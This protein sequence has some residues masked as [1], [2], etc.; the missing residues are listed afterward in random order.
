LHRSLL[1]GTPLVVSGLQHTFQGE[2][3]P[4]YFIE[5][6]GHHDVTVMD[7]E[8]EQEHKLTVAEFFRTFG[9][10]RNGQQ[11]LKLKVRV[12]LTRS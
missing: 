11:V 6:Y 5:A 7:C 3:G 9:S 4:E 10:E 1:T 2:W 12:V 8:T